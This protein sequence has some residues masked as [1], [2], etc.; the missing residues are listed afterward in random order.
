MAALCGKTSEQCRSKMHTAYAEERDEIDPLYLKAHQ[1]D[2]MLDNVR[3]Q[4][5]ASAEDDTAPRPRTR[6]DAVVFVITRNFQEFADF[7]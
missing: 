1:A 4:F 5:D 6:A 7:F 3:T 2:L